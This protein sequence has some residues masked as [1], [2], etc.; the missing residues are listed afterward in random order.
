MSGNNVANSNTALGKLSYTIPSVAELLRLPSLFII[1]YLRCE[2]DI[3]TL[4]EE[5]EEKTLACSTDYCYIYWKEA[6]TPDLL[7]VV[8]QVTFKGQE[9]KFYVEASSN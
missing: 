5:G 7:R 1:D 2:L 9:T 3:V 8:P 4:S 6:H